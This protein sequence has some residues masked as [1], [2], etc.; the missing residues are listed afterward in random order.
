VWRR[1]RLPELPGTLEGTAGAAE[2][3]EESTSFRTENICQKDYCAFFRFV[4]LRMGSAPMVRCFRR[5]MGLELGGHF[6]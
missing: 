1:V 3:S 2:A 4:S 6:R 5:R